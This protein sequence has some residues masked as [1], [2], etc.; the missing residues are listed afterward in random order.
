MKIA[1]KGLGLGGSVHLSLPRTSAHMMLTRKICLSLR[2]G[3]QPLL[4]HWLTLGKSSGQGRNPSSHA[5]LDEANSPTIVLNPGPVF[6][7]PAALPSFLKCTLSPKSFCPQAMTA[8]QQDLE[9]RLVLLCCK[10]RQFQSQAESSTTASWP[11]PLRTF[12]AGGC[13]VTCKHI[14]SVG[15]GSSGKC[16]CSQDEAKHVDFKLQGRQ[17]EPTPWGLQLRQSMRV[18]SPRGSS[19]P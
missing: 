13:L 2:R 5:P 18:Q 15:C 6:Q 14:I 17:P 10:Y 7:A 19:E 4:T 9:P 3:T 1:G 8:S 16:S 11:T 12:C